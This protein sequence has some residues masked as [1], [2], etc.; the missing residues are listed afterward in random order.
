MPNFIKRVLGTLLLD[1]SSRAI[2]RAAEI[3]RRGGLVAFPTETV[4][5][6]GASALNPE[7][8]EKIFTAKGRPADN[9]LIVH[10]ADIGQLEL[11]ASKVTAQ[12]RILA[13]TFWPGALS[14]VLP[15]TEV[16]PFQVSAGLDTVAVRM[17]SHPLAIELIRQA[18]VPIAAPSA[19]RS[20]RASPTNWQHVL[21]DLAGRVDA[22]ICEYRCAIGVESTVLDLSGAKP[23]ILRPGGVTREALEKVLGCPVAVTGTRFREGVPS[24]PGM[25]YRH[26]APRA[27]LILITGNPERRKLFIKSLVENRQGQGLSVGIIRAGC[28]WEDDT[29]AEQQQLSSTLYDELRAMDHRQVD[30][31]IAEAT[32][33]DGLGL[34]LM[35]RL[36]KAAC[37]VLRVT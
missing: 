15:K 34:A 22:V 25:K 21:E 8:L 6:L 5:G 20:G 7:A 17:P 33:P 36:R 37:R 27:P 26:Y 30:L 28:E 14:L 32:E 1:G 19:N 11:V 23:V 24:S 10:I 13:D 35:N 9:P 3:I 12:V 2:K 29:P 18:G 31:I 16:I 4:Y